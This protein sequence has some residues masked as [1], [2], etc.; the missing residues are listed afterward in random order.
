[1]K[2]F[3]LL[4]TRE[5]D[6]IANEEYDS[7]LRYSGLTR[8][9]LTRI[10]LEQAPMPE[11]QLS[12]YSGIIVGGSP[13]NSSDPT[14]SK[15]PTQIR[16]EAELSALLDDIVAQDYPFLGACYGVG[17]LG[18]HQGGVVD[19]TYGEPVSTTTIE[20]TAEGRDDPLLAG[21]P[22]TFDA[23][24][25]HKEALSTPP[26]HATVLATSAR[27]PVQMFRVKSNVYATQFHP[28]LDSESIV[29]RLRVYQHSGYFPPE[30]LDSL[31]LEVAQGK[32]PH[33]G[34]VLRTF[35]E[36]YAQGTQ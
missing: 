29:H 28:E 19:R 22:N 16:V 23:F 2:P 3:L 10:R 9:Q 4:S 14:E 6:V 27:C 34:K 1:M 36:R 13:Y 26:P 30:E 8:D 5:I 7:V 32:V 24:V 17:T 21:I 12:D 18:I 20:I 31:I 25:G 15:S 35:V 33:S 11:I